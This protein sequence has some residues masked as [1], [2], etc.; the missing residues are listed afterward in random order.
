MPVVMDALLFGDVGCINSADNFL[1]GVKVED[2]FL[3]R[4]LY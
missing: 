1:A 3:A 4:T 2:I